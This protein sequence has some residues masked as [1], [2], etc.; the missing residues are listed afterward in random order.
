[1]DCDPGRSKKRPLRGKGVLGLVFSLSLLS[2]AVSVYAPVYFGSPSKN[3][4]FL[5][6]QIPLV[7]S[8]SSEETHEF[9]SRESDCCLLISIVY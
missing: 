4:P 7:G 6:P 9:V 1:M 2:S 3:S 5:P 8:P